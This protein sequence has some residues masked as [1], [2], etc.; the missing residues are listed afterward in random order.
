MK[1]TTTAKWCL[2]LAA[3]FSVEAF[4]AEQQ[5]L[6]EITVR[7]SKEPPQEESL[8]IREVRES[9]ARDMGE[10]LKQ[11]EGINS[12]R[13]GAI[14]NDVVIRG[15]QKDNI[16]VFVDGVRL[17]G[18]C[19]SRMDPPSFHF[20]FAEIEQVR[21]VKG[22]Y[23]LKNPGGLGG[24]I[25]AQ[26]R[27]PGQGF[28]SDL[29]LT[30]GSWNN[31]N[32]SATGS[33]GSER[34]DG[35]LGY[36]FKQSGV[37]KAGNHK[38]ITDIYPASSANRYKPGEIDATAY[39]INS[40][41]LKFGLNPTGNSRSEIS[42]SY[43][44]ADHVLYPYLKMDADYDRTHR[45]NW[46]YRLRK[47]SPLVQDLKLQAYW[48]KIAHVMDD[49]F[50]FSSTP[51]MA[52]TRSYS[53]KTDAETQVYGVK[54][55]TSLAAGPGT[56]NSGLDYYNR[57]WDAL[58]QRAMYFAYRDH[59]L[60]PDV[61]IDNLG[62]F[63]EYE[64]PIGNQWQ[65]KGGVRGDLT[66]AEAGKGN[67]MVAAGTSTDFSEVSANLQ[68]TYEPVKGVELFTGLGRGV[69]TPDPQELYLDL[70]GTPVWRGNQGLKPTVNHQADIGIKYATNRFYVNT[71]LF[72]SDL[73]DYVNFYQ[74]SPTLKSYQNIDASMWGAELGSQVALPLDLF[75]RGSLSYVEAEN[76][77]DNRPL[78][79]I[80]PLKGAISLRYDNGTAFIELLENMARRQDR[81]D[82][83]LNEQE[84][85]GWATT[86]LK[87]GYASM[88]F[89]V[90]AGVNNLFD[91]YY[92][93]H[94]SYARDPFV[95]GVGYKVPENGRN[96]YL[97]AQYKF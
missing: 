90:Y 94:L 40:G 2:V 65:L 8:T 97:T 20:D 53:M 18:A 45:L 9:P 79:E 47:I 63:A 75:L 64:L 23:D 55:T 91:Q 81:T 86:D 15:F 34:Y 76:E 59:A 30:Y 88:G 49:R 83:G 52:V 5:L 67:T 17:H 41:W 26:T 6:D 33:Y 32:A 89:T 77:T 48:D 13:K 80:P 11:V 70:P 82:P 69:R 4:G 43:Q 21:I 16:N 3:M 22:P 38:L 84:T 93:N 85:A 61:S 1:V 10:A 87:A 96:F 7:G 24:M 72:Y 31:V 36:A 19:P 78:A 68:L 46:S 50:R 12:V 51:S 62:M 27:R 73:T 35:L 56:L 71:S 29:S 60:I 44:D 95:G 25:D 39:E 54:F 92:F 66:W 74:A 37:P 57:N 42:Y 28:G 14:A 58:N